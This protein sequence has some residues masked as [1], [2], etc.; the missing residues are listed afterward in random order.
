MASS[1]MQPVK[2]LL[3]LAPR[4]NIAIATTELAAGE[5][6]LLDGRIVRAL[7]RIATGHKIAIA[8]IAEG[9]KVMKF[10][11][12]IGSA[13]VD[14]PVGRHVHTHNV[15]SDYIPTFTLEKGSTFV[16]EQ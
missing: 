2:R 8:P 10:A 9:A 13:T 3:R 16:K 5:E 15:K 6:A 1:E 12:P 4:D 7:D 14:I 11:C